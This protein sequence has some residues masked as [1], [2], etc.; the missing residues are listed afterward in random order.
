ME[1]G[2]LL[3]LLRDRLMFVLRD[4]A[5]PCAAAATPAPQRALLPCAPPKQ[6]A[7]PPAWALAGLVCWGLLASSEQHECAR[8]N[9]LRR[10]SS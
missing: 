10:A 1:T 6:Q 2:A 3:L 4:G 7:R 9:S 8:A 5:S